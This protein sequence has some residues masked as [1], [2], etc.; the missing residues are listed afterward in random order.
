VKTPDYALTEEYSYN[1]GYDKKTVSAG[2]FVRPIETRYVPKHV[3]EDERWK[4]IKN[5][6]YVFCYWRE[7][8]MPFPRKIVRQV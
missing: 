6:E 2:T 8:I 5:D 4:Y 1:E 7:G 3:T